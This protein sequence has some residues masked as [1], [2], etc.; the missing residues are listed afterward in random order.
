MRKDAWACALLLT[1]LFGLA[2]CGGS[3]SDTSP[4]T[5]PPPVIS[6]PANQAPTISNLR[7]S[8][9]P[10]EAGDNVTF[11]W[12]AADSDGDTLRCT[13]DPTGFGPVYELE[14]CAGESSITHT[15]DDPGTFQAR[16]DVSDGALEN[17]ASLNQRVTSDFTVT[18]LAPRANALVDTPLRVE[19]RVASPLEV[20]SVTATIGG[21]SAAL[22]FSPE[23]NRF[24]GTLSLSGLARGEQLLQVRARDIEGTDTTATMAVT[25]DQRPTVS[26]SAP[27]E[28]TASDGWLRVTASCS[29][30]DPAGCALRV[31]LDGTSTVLAS[32]DIALDEEID[33]SEYDGRALNLRF[34]ARDSA[35]QAVFEDRTVYVETSAALVR[36]E[37]FPGRV[38]DIQGERILYRI[39]ADDGDQLE[40][41]NRSNGGTEVVDL[42]AGVRVSDSASFLTPYGAVFTTQD[43][44]GTVLSARIYD[45]NRGVLEDLGDP[46]SASSLDVAG[47]YA[48]WS[49][50][51]VPYD[52]QRIMLRDLATRTNVIVSNNA[53]NWQNDVAEN[54]VVAFWNRSYDI[55]L[56]RDG[57]LT[58][59]TDDT[60]VWNTWVVTDGTR[61]VYRKHTPCCSNQ[62]YAIVLHDGNREIELSPAVSAEPSPGR[63]YQLVSDWVAYTDLGNLG[64]RHVWLYGPTGTRQQLT[65]F[66]TSSRIERLAPSGELMLVN[67]Q[68]YHATPGGVL[69]EVGSRLGVPYSA[70]DRWLIAIGR[71]VFAW[72]G[73]P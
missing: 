4:P 52:G 39:A 29:D 33:L 18:I 57:V 8:A 50:N 40:I 67:T 2:A 55:E 70:G 15:F 13:F 12:S 49:T 3:G 68:R 73:A 63:D 35:N 38:L 64:Q 69:S 16:L 7:S 58:A 34:E 47:D 53:G 32:G 24:V 54:G 11:T 48:M 37:D 43:I 30:D 21:R 65:F 31:M 56:Y 10:S 19:A 14:D 1:G 9:N 25:Y 26:V 17:T 6:P 66:G 60:E 27:L 72:V 71:S 61:A 42:P 5:D 44:G 46:N 22:S 23:E 28:F 36:L 41:F 20:A 51:V 62:V 59:L 45:W